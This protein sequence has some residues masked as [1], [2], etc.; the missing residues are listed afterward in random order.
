MTAKNLASFLGTS[1]LDG[2]IIA[3]DNIEQ[4]TQKGEEV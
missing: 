2:E 3:I 1:N 4:S